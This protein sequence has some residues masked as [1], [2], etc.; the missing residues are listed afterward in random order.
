MH[1][2]K[3]IRKIVT[4][5][6][7]L[8][9]NYLS[10]A[11]PQI[12]NPTYDE[13]QGV[14][15]VSNS[16]PV[17]VDSYDKFI[18]NATLP[19]NIYRSDTNTGNVSIK[20]AAARV[21]GDNSPLAP[22]SINELARALK[23]DPDLIYQFVRN[24]IEFVPMW[25]I[26]KGAVGTLLDNQGTDFDQAVLLVKLLN[27]AGYTNTAYIRGVIKLNAA[28]LKSWLGRDI[29]NTCALEAILGN[30]RIPVKAIVPTASC[31]TLSPV[32]SAS[33][34]HIWVRVNIGGTDYVFD[35]SYK[36]HNMIAG[37]DIAA[38]SGYNAT[39]YLSNALV[40]STTTADYTQS[41][42]RTNIRNDLTTYANNMANYLRSNKPAAS[43]DD[44]LGGA[45]I[46]PT[47]TATLRQTSLSYQ[48]ISYTPVVVTDIDVFRPTLK[49]D[50]GG[51][52]QTFFADDI[53]GKRLLVTYVGNQPKLTLDGVQIGALGTA[54]TAGTQQTITLTPTHTAYGTYNVFNGVLNKGL[55]VGSGY[56]YMIVNSFGP[57]GR[58]LALSYRNTLQ[59]K[60]AAGVANTDE[61]VLGSSLGV[62]SGQWMAQS[63]FIAYIAGKLADTNIMHHHQIGLAGYT[64]AAYIDLPGVAISFDNNAKD[65]VKEEAAYTNYAMHS[66]V[67]ESTAVSQTTGMSAVSTGKLIDM[68]VTLGQPIYNATSANYTSIVRPNL[69][70]CTTNQLNTYATRVGTYDRVI[71]PKS[72]SITEGVFTGYGYYVKKKTTGILVFGNIISGNLYGGFSS[73]Q[74][75]PPVFNINT[76]NYTKPS[77]GSKAAVSQFSVSTSGVA[78]TFGDPIDMVQGN[79]L[80]SHDDISVGA[81]AAPLALAFSRQYSSGLNAQDGPLGKGWTHNLAASVAESSDGFQGLGEDSALDAVGA[82]VEH[83]ISHDLFMDLN[84]PIDKVVIATIGQ[85]WFG[86]QISN[87]TVIVQQGLN[88]EVFVK[89]P[90]GSYNPPPGKSSKLTLSN[91]IYTYEGVNKDKLVFNASNATNGAN[92]VA[93]YSAP[94]G[95]E[96]KYTYSGANLTSVSNS[97]G[98]SLT[99]TYTG[100]RITQVADGNGR[101]V[102]YG[103]NTTTG[104]LTSYTD[105]LAKIT[106]YQY[107]IPGRMTKLF[108][109]SFPTIAAATN[110]YDTLGRVQTQ[111]NAVGGLYNYYFAGSRSEEVGPG[112]KSIV[113]YLDNM[114]NILKSVDPVGRITLNDYDNQSRLIKTTFPEGNYT[115]YTYDDATCA[116]AEKR[117]THNVK[118]I[119][120]TP[121]S[122]SGLSPLTQS[123]TYESAFNKVASATD[124]R[125]YVTNYTYTTFGSPQTVTLPTDDSGVA[126]V[127]TFT[128]SSFTPTASGFTTPFNLLTSTTVKTNASN[129]VTNAITY[130]TAANKFV[131]L[132][133]V[134]DSGTG[135]LNLTSTFTYDAV[136]NLTGVNG[137][138][139]DV[140][141]TVAIAYDAARQ[142][143]QV[144]N[145]LSKLTK[146]AYDA[147]GRATIVASQLGAA[148]MVSCTNYSASGK[149]IK[150]WGPAQTASA[151]T[152]PAQAAPVSVTD[153]TYDTIDRVDTVTQNLTTAQG[154]NRV[155][156]TNYNLD[157][158]IQSVQRAVGTALEQTYAAYTYTNNGQ[159]A[160]VKDAKNN[161]TTYQYDGFDRLS[162]VNYPSIT[163]PGTSSSTDFEQYGY[164]NNGNVTSLRKR[165]G[166]TITQTYDKLNRLTARSYPSAADNRTYG[167]DLRG[168]TLASQY[169]NGSN[170]I[171]N[172]WDNAGRLLST[173]SAGRT[174]NYEYDLASNRTKVTWPDSF[175]V[176]T[177]YDALNRPV[178][179]K[180]NGTTSLANYA[181]DDLSRRTT[182]TLGN[183]TSTGYLYDTQGSLS[184]LE[185][186]LAGTAQDV[187]FTYTRN[188]LQDIT[189]IDVTNNNYVWTGSPQGT[190]NYT[191]N[192]LNQYASLTN[193]SPIS[194]SNTGNLTQL[195]N[196][197]YGYDT[198]DRLTSAD[199]NTL[200]YDADDRL[201]KTTFGGSETQFLY[202]GED[203]VGEYNSL[204]A[205]Q[206]RYVHAPGVDEP[207]VWYEGSSTTNKNWYYADQQGSVVALANT[208]GAVTAMYS[209][210]PDGKPASNPQRFGY[211]GQQY[212]AQINLHYYKARMYN[213]A[214]GRFMQTDPIGY[215]DDMNLYAYVGNDQVNNTDP[216]GLAGVTLGSTQSWTGVSGSNSAQS[217]FTGES[218]NVAAAGVRTGT[219]PSPLRGIQEQTVQ[220]LEYE[221]RQ[222]DPSFRNHTISA[223]NSESS[224]LDGNIRY[225][226]GV[227]NSFNRYPNKVGRYEEHHVEPVYLG[228]PRNGETVRIPA[229]YH[230]VIT[231][232]FRSLRGYGLGYPSQSEL[233]AI[234][235]S[236][237]SKFP[238]P[239]R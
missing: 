95:L 64:S 210:D 132:T 96:V 151:T 144:T 98:R 182:T 124:A 5:V 99:F 146:T 60:L 237:Y 66:G 185:H 122:G 161:L 61:S 92:K 165:S 152:C 2:K 18:V 207:L 158:S 236:V 30:S 82:L 198:D 118:T 115:Q 195:G 4:F 177:S 80:Y 160:T 36:P 129:T 174:L 29:A 125:G 134:A 169:T 89:L 212:L 214:L 226:E 235:N 219:G 69:T 32:T 105:P 84:Y 65:I 37:M 200:G 58:G 48:D 67:L 227:I 229:P 78:K 216:N 112:G 73:V 166:S 191:A 46:V 63:S 44:V 10:H 199:S 126:P 47:S 181:Y 211:T 62:L 23:N 51:I 196:K 208:T 172:S 121:K 224:N 123:F 104:D 155:S 93:T 149:P 209:Y 16:K 171:T 183:G 218:Y 13:N 231:N 11:A 133:S 145:A 77:V 87:N 221:I 72:C 228:G 116:S 33:I 101:S 45:T 79:F 230:Q 40:G 190:S 147:D 6:A 206:R 53:Y 189:K 111:T 215:A 68:A 41:I 70:G 205:L 167:Y 135:K 176:T 222:V 117:C 186:F 113:S 42:N 21:A 15:A 192:G 1:Q 188:Q 102:T 25:G 34:E 114:G 81:G 39:T 150:T 178:D 22:A 9:A 156:K 164:D 213:S 159:K 204:N 75:T 193:T 140:A 234:K 233:E 35:P 137:P 232:E 31:T 153:I 184:S 238:L 71:M 127:T 43:I 94:N 175:Y 55:L 50:I 85:R 203:L 148:W 141:D 108:Y 91:G 56:T 120:S 138:R 173:T 170:V 90:D 97:L 136:G 74:Y 12:S 157:D 103:Y 106:T 3:Y 17:S 86:D 131:P 8:S 57:V 76:I 24:N 119:V 14:I 54:G 239:S 154:G 194:Y 187:K 27:A 142:P 223:P 139:T 107:D 109:P 163:T 38:I 201:S 225:L 180:E 26:Q 100:S 202:D 88:G 19:T 52:S 217:A 220:R 162:K 49:V 110:T 168:L 179:I 128:Y 20:T 130:N 143:T 197:T 7:L 59:D 83:K 28:E